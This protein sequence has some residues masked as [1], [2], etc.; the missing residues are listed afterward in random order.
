MS[1]AVKEP[2]HDGAPVDLRDRLTMGV[3]V[4]L[5]GSE[6]DGCPLSQC[7]MGGVEWFPDRE[8]AVAYCD[9]VPAVFQPHILRVTAGPI[10]GAYR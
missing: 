6:E 2:P 7:P 3:V 8:H 1:D 9:T 5:F 4:V 10:D